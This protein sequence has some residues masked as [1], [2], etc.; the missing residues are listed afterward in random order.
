MHSPEL[1]ARL[2][3]ESNTLFLLCATEL[4]ASRSPGSSTHLSSTPLS[5]LKSNRCHSYPKLITSI[6]H[7]R[8]SCPSGYSIYILFGNTSCPCGL[9]MAYYSSYYVRRPLYSDPLDGPG[10]P[11]CSCSKYLFDTLLIPSPHPKSKYYNNPFYYANYAAIASRLGDSHAFGEQKL[12][13][14]KY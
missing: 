4:E 5:S 8:P 10:S 13:N 1:V 3:L 6:N 7:S 9:I 12:Y 14:R 11:G 2:P